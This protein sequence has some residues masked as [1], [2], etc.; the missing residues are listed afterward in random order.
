ML[1]SLR[2]RLL[3]SFVGLVGLVL[4]VV[5][6]GLVLS[7][8]K[9]PILYRQTVSGV[10][11]SA[12][13]VSN[14]LD[15]RVRIN[16]NTAERILQKETLKHQTE[17]LLTDPDGQVIAQSL[18][19]VDV[20]EALTLLRSYGNQAGEQVKMFTDSAGQIWI[21]NLTPVYNVGE[22]LTIGQQ[23]AVR[24]R[25][26]L[27]DE[28]VSPI[29]KTGIWAI[30]LA[31][32][33]GVFVSNWIARPISKIA[34][35]AGEANL[36]QDVPVEGPLEVR[37]LAAGLNGMMANVRASQQSQRDFMAN[38]SHELKTPLTSIQGFSQSI[39]DGTA[40]SPEMINQSASIIHQESQRMVRMVSDLLVLARLEAGTT[41]FEKKPID[42]NVL[43][44]SMAEKFAIQAQSGQIEIQTQLNP[45]PLIQGDGDRLA[46]VLNNL[47]DNAIKFTQPH[48]KVFVSST[49][50]DGFV[51]ISVQTAVWVLQLKICP[52]FLN[53]FT[54]QTKRGV[55][56]VCAA[57]VLD[58]RSRNKLFVRMGVISVCRAR[59]GRA[60]YL[61]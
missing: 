9:S 46:Q 19:K 52:E 37:Q 17:F 59:L 26:L 21:Y 3:F 8:L 36:N 39:M 24:L 60:A 22:L 51:R 15:N 28:V 33:L 50:V 45:L 42:L 35:V 44:K 18:S 6:I 31:I 40:Q 48:G 30:V 29:L 2:L 7:L 23:P 14:Q 10:R 4:F 54:R 57:W 38:V 32:I 47:V 56:V 13:I 12:A 49:L 27:R 41:D 53:G 25:T 34:K 61:W 43:L 5:T 20:Q 1:K 16:A 55:K 11:I 58:C